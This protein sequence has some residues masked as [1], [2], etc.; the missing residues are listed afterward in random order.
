M[1]RLV[2]LSG[3]GGTGKTTVAAALAQLAAGERRLVLVDAD[4][5]AANLGLLLDPRER[6]VTDFVGAET[7]AID[8]GACTACGLCAEAC[9]FE[10]IAVSGGAYRVDPVA[11]EGCRACLYVCPEAA[12][13]MAP[14]LSGR[15]YRSDTRLG[16]LFHAHLLPGQENSG[17][18]VTALRRDAEAWA[19]RERPDVMLVD[20][21]P[22]IGCP[23]IAAA[24]G[25]DL[26][27]LVT[28]PTPAAVHDFRRILGTL[29]HFGIP[30]L[31]CVNKADLNAERREEIRAECAARGVALLGDIPYDEA[32]VDAVRAGRP[33]TDAAAPRL[34]AAL[35]GIWRA[36][37]PHLDA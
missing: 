33:V 20:G 30:A 22:G 6:E 17:K 25:A 23:V 13:A 19:E 1:K 15:R 36:L 27:L 4:V 21:P 26:A 37:V 32:A 29:E 2:V 8:A 10:A 31:A 12:I 9:R 5:D 14:Q 24:S 11:C 3:K 35:A 16:P 28:E 7:A 18:L 34:A